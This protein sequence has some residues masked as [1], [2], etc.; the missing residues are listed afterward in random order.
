MFQFS[1]RFDFLSTFL[2]SN[3]TPKAI[4]FQSWALFLRH[5]V[6]VNLHDVKNMAKKIKLRKIKNIQK[7]RI[8]DSNAILG[9]KHT[10]YLLHVQPSGPGFT[11]PTTTCKYAFSNRNEVKPA[12]F[13][14]TMSK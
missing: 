2:L 8:T 4:P 1:C 7:L 13:T 3:R 9:V 5:S 11:K 6:V 14:H 12:I 10:T